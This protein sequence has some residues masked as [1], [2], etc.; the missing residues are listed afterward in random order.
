MK[1][2]GQGKED[3][4]ELVRAIKSTAPVSGLTHTYY[5]YPARFS[6][7]FAREVIK[8][9][10]QLGDV[11]LDP[12][13]GGGTTLV[14]ARALGR[15]A[16]GSDVSSL[17]VFLA[18]AKTMLLSV[19][20]REAVFRWANYIVF[21]ALNL[22]KPAV[23]DKEWIE[24]GYQRNAS[25]RFTWA[26]R[27]IVELALAQL[28]SLQTNRQR[29]FA[30]CAVLRTA[31]WAL[32]CRKVVP[33][34]AEFR[35]QFLI[36]LNEMV[37]GSEEFSTVCGHWPEIT[38]PLCLHQSAVTLDETYDQTELKPPRLVLTSPPY[39]GV[40]VVYHRWQVFG[41]RE[42]PAAFWIAGTKD[43][44]GASFY[45]FGSRDQSGLSD[46]FHTALNAFKAI[47]KI[48]DKRT[49]I[50]QMVAFSEDRWQL[51]RYLKVMNEAG[52]E[53]ISNNGSSDAPSRT[54]RSVPNRKWYATKQGR[55]SSSSEVVLFHRLAR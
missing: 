23:R 17:A 44:A 8:R 28:A 14:E 20:D 32:D 10:T 6:P 51:V 5:C 50:V 49:T 11:V 7:L 43:G 35:A 9:F 42:T 26:I 22:R 15:R 53:E 18:K 34:A 25:S 1:V 19:V 4:S 29:M 3:F 16:V 2:E 47:A 39:P 30:R 33:S 46:Y 21:D 37:L 12:F 45:T 41:R 27:K 13:M 55:T 52:F 31:Q 54:W 48:A 36:F 38:E 24:E 40:H